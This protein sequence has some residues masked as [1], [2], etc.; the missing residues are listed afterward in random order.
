M[1]QELEQIAADPSRYRGDWKRLA[2]SGYWRLRV[3]RYRAICDVRDDELVVLVHTGP[4]GDI[5]K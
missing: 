1:I 3:G 2:G 4:R 5:Y